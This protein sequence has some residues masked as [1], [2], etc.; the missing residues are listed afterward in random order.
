[1]KLA[2][3]RAIDVMPWEG[4]S[5]GRAVSCTASSCSATLRYS[6]ETGR[7]TLRVQ[8]F[9]QNNGSARMRVS[10]AGR[11]V[12]QWTLADHVP[13][14]KIDSSSSARRTISGVMLRPGD[15]I[16]IEGWPDG[17]ELAA[18]VDGNRL[19]HVVATTIAF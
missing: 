19:E 10:V 13:S 7:R 3:Y 11:L 1:M 5:G 9:D 18:L 16:R 2:G 17:G 12:D 6:G 8:Y 14:A 15:E 4:A